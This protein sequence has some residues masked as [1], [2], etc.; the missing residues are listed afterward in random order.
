M[1]M[2]KAE[3][4]LRNWHLTTEERPQFLRDVSAFKR[5]LVRAIRED[6]IAIYEDWEE[7]PPGSTVTFPEAV[8][9][10]IRWRVVCGK[11]TARDHK[12]RPCGGKGRGGR[13]K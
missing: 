9:K 11:D 7:R 1:K 13:A 8:R 3:K 4:E 6:C 10:G 5:A 12:T 2:L